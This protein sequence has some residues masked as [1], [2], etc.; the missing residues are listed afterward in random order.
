MRIET[1]RSYCL[2]RPGTTEDRPFDLV[3]IVM[4]VGGKI[5]ALFDDDDPVKS[6]SLKCDPDHALALRSQ[7]P[8]VTGGYHLNK[9]HWNTVALDGTIPPREIFEMI[10]ESYDLVLASLPKKVRESL[11]S[12]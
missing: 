5:Y 8:A 9:K 2:S 4:R 7:Y 3:T 12:E 11:S 6:I 1:I 10:D